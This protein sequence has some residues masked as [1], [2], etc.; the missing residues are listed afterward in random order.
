MRA[1]GLAAIN[2]DKICT[3][4]TQ[5]PDVEEVVEDLHILS[6]YEQEYCRDEG[7]RCYLCLGGSVVNTMY[8]L[9]K[10]NLEVHIFGRVG[11]DP[12]GK[13][14][15]DK[16]NEFNMKFCGVVTPGPSGRTLVLS[17]IAT[18]RILVYP[19]VN[20]YL[21]SDDVDAVLSRD[22]KLVH[23][24]TFA[25]TRGVGPLDAQVRVFREYVNS[26]KS[27]MFGSLYCKL[28]NFEKFKERILELMRLSN[29][30]FL[31]R[32][33]A[34]VVF[35]SID[36]HSVRKFVEHSNISTICVTLGAEG[37]LVINKNGKVIRRRPVS[38]N[39]VDVTG[40]GDAFA[41]GFLLGLVKG[42]DLEKCVELGLYAAASCISSICGTG[43]V[44][45]CET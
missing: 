2:L 34:E 16:M 38:S 32:S 15:L 25:C 9:A 35:S 14:L 39:V 41:G 31:N 26:I 3:V 27:F 11:N 21:N 19:G 17:G 10:C 22:Y 28:L 45:K 13:F 4:N 7:C 44:L 24:S 36:I 20:D 12:E 37:V 40:A 5:V 18:R 23:T 8:V 30:V 43:Y 6:K 42:L 1:L 33:E 29:V